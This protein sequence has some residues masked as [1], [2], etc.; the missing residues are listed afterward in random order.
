VYRI[1]AELLDGMAG[2]LAALAMVALEWFRV[3]SVL[4]TSHEPMLLMGLLLTWTWLRW[5]AS[6]RRRGAWAALMGVFAGWGAI[7]RPVDALCFAIPV[8][9]AVVLDVLKPERRAG[10][11]TGVSPVPQAPH[12]ADDRERISAAGSSESLRS[13]HGR[14][15]RVTD[16]PI[17]HGRLRA[18][19][20]TLCLVVAGAAPFL[21]VQA[22]FNIGVTGSVWDTPYAYYLRQDQPN[23]SFGFH[24]Y[25]PMA[26]PVSVVPQK[27]AYYQNFFLPYVLR[28]QPSQVLPWWGRVYAGQ[29]V[30]TSLPARPLLAFLP[31]GLLALHGRGRKVLAAS[32][33][34]FVLLYMGN[35]FFLE[36]YAILIAPAALM[37]AL[38]GLRRTAKAIAPRWSSQVRIGLSMAFIAVCL[39][40]LPES[41]PL[42]GDRYEGND[43]TFAAPLMQRVRNDVP[44]LPESELHRPAVILFRW[45]PGQNIQEEPVYNTGS[46]W[47][48]DAPIIF[49]HDLGPE[50]NREVFRYYADREPKRFFYRWDRRTGQVEDLGYARDLAKPEGR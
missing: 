32:L 21:A 44:N 20:V 29:A 17:G 48:D 18:L 14:D 19:G 4:L 11:D 47:P 33:P 24:P 39:L 27:Q 10:R 28:H 26:R 9:V 7:T 37:L 34:L 49:A 2:L 41:N 50:R 13:S 38:L 23:T 31:V 8:G 6:E 43:E 45:G 36:H 3:Y 25:D 46:V 15:A 16:A 1:V 35:T 12:P 40:S 5:R 30:D 42:F 22:V